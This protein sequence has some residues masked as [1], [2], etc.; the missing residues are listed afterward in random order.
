MY[1]LL[2]HSST[3]AHDLTSVASSVWSLMLINA[4]SS[5]SNP[6]LTGDSQGL[7]MVAAWLDLLLEHCGPKRLSPSVSLSL[8][9]LDNTSGCLEAGELRMLEMRR[10]NRRE[11]S[12][13]KAGYCDSD[14]HQ[15]DSSR[16]TP[17]S[18]CL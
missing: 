11:Y 8:E 9:S 15:G 6:R 1:T 4:C 5:L 18:S 3:I 13:L 16:L 17:L 7:L 12:C 14:T 10:K 2:L